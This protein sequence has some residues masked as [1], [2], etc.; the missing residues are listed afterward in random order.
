MCGIAGVWQC[1]PI[2]AGID[3]LLGDMLA[4]IHH[5]GPDGTRIHV[6]RAAQ[7][8]MGHTRLA[9][10]DLETGAQPLFDEPRERALT[11]NG[12]FYDYKRIRADLV[13]RGHRF[14]TKSDSEIALPLYERRGLDFVDS[15]RGE[16]ALALYDRAADRLVL[17]RD[18]FG[19]KPLFYYADRER[20]IYASEIKALFAH[21]QV[22]RRMSAKGVLRQLMHV[23]VPGATAFEHVH[24]VKPGH[25]LVV[26]RRD[27]RLEVTERRYWDLDFPREHERDLGVAAETQIEQVREQMIEAVQLRL[28]ADVPVG[29]Y[30]SGGID[31]CSILGLATAVQQSPVKA[32]TIG[33]DHQA[34]DESDVALEM[35]HAVRADH[36]TFVMNA[37]DLYGD[38]YTRC[39]WH[40]ERAFYN[41]LGVAKWCLSERVRERGY[42]VVVTGEGADELFGGYPAFKRDMILHGM[43]GESPDEVSALQRQLYES[44]RIF[45]GAILSE[46]SPTHPAME[47]LC[48]FTPSWI[49][50][51]LEASKV[52]RPLLADDLL[53]QLEGYDPVEELAASL[54]ASQFEGRH[55]LDKAQYTYTKTLLEVQVLGWSGDRADMANSIEA[56]PAF[57]DHHVAE[58]ARTIPPSRR[59]HGMVEKWVLREAM[60]GILPERLYKRQK[61][62]FMAPPP[63]TG[64]NRRKAVDRLIDQHMGRSQVADAGLFDPGRLDAFLQSYRVEHDPTAL[65]RKDA[66]L[67]HLL[68]LHMLHQRFVQGS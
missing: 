13:S 50:P 56:R 10:I 30:L 55:P 68:G 52:A 1:A 42:K 59:I 25:M 60:H 3:T 47:A 18:R 7:L 54:D 41:A 2:E 26:S 38:N 11:V 21:P 40:A 20:L 8:A 4:T 48:G 37:E 57:L 53:A 12:E 23:P 31:S 63:H 17:A 43:A 58:L 61:F 45:K 9:I 51:W 35:A 28:E 44:N 32:F 15:L 65:T 39:L 22:P 16:F 49:Q 24:K 62:A 19:I 14:A 36:E 27:G 6:D 67:N 33:F 64:P 66:L 46:S 5:R 29:C 34:Y